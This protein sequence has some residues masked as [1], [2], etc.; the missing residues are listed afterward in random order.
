MSNNTF[1]IKSS[2]KVNKSLTV[3]YYHKSTEKSYF[4][5]CI[6]VVNSYYI[7]LMKA[8]SKKEEKGKEL[9]QPLIDVRHALTFLIPKSQSSFKYILSFSI[10]YPSK[11]CGNNQQGRRR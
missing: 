8:Q 7:P 4:L 1:N 3:S 11:L 10:S 9:S 2:E 5:F 6:G